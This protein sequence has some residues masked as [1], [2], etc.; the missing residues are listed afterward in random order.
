MDPPRRPLGLVLALA[1]AATSVGSTLLAA[2]QGEGRPHSLVLTA[3]F[4]GLILI[5]V[6]VTVAGGR[7]RPDP[8]RR[9]RSG[10]GGSSSRQDAADLL[11]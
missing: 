1:G 9:P 11:Y 4:L 6:G 8:G 10:G 3:F 5:V 2:F 7:E